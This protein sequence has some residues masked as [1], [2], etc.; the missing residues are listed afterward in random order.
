MIGIVEAIRSSA[1]LIPQIFVAWSL[2][3]R[4]VSKRRMVV[5]FIFSRLSLALVAPLILL[6]GRQRPALALAGLFVLFTVFFVADA[7]GS[8]P[9][10]DFLTVSLSPVSRSRLI[11]TAQAL[12]G[13]GG[14]GCSFVV[15][16][17]L[18][19]PV[20]AF[21]ASYSILFAG[22]GG[23]MALEVVAISFLRVVPDDHGRQRIPLR[24]FLPWLARLLARDRDFR[25]LIIVR[26]LVGGSGLSL[27]FY[28]VFGFDMLHLGPQSV[29][30]FTG[31]QVVGGI[32]SAPLMALLSEK[33]GTRSVIRLV[34]VLSLLLPLLGLCLFL[35]KGAL[36]TTVLLGLSAAI[37]FLLGGVNNGNMAGF[38]NYL[39]EHA[40]S[41]QR[42]VYV[43]LANTLN[44]FV[45]V[46]PV[47]GGWI[48]SATS[49]PVLFAVTAVV[50]LAGLLGTARLSP[51]AAQSTPAAHSPQST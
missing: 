47:I 33:R 28:I 40:P 18:A 34:A 51:P 38:N 5:P 48:L 39:L 12:A 17:I 36:G 2:S 41:V 31:A 21:P 11:G 25:K 6:A 43:G 30:I 22:A 9:W 14:I 23:F 10:F 49:Y 29:G 26:L 44:G 45:L 37:F 8:L 4:A 16:R 3:G 20:P 13:A 19:G 42:A 15:A 50:S 32:V 46:A 27:P 35:L 24:T 7:F 1:W